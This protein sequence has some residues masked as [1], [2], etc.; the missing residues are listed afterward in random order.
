MALAEASAPGNPITMALPLHQLVR[1]L[2]TPSNMSMRC[3]LIFSVLALLGGC[4][5]TGPRILAPGS[6]LQAVA[7][8][9]VKADFVALGELHQTPGVHTVHHQLL[10][11]MHK[12]RPNMVIAMEMFERD[13]QTVLTQYL[14]GVIDEDEF[15]DRS[16]PWPHY[17]RDYRP[18]IEFAKQ[19]KLKVLAAN[20][21]RPLARQAAQEGMQ[22]V[23]G[24]EHLARST[25]APRDDYW[26]SFQEMMAGHG[27][28]F[29]E[30]GMERFYAA[31]CLKDDTMAEAIVDHLAAAAA[32]SR[33]LAVLICGRAHSDHGWGAVQRVVQR[34]PGIDVRVLTAETVDDLADAVI[35]V[36]AGVADYVVVAEARPRGLDGEGDSAHRAEQNAEGLRPAF[37]FMPDYAGGDEGVLVGEVLAGRP[38]AAAGIE[39]GDRIVCVNGLPTLDL[40]AYTEALDTLKIGSTVKVRVSREGV[41][42]DLDVKVGSRSAR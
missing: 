16:R 41:E 42:V 21:P 24:N 7:D 40:E 19:N 12:R 15:C 30:D 25:T 3:S 23:Q 26:D 10:R 29:G 11:A 32:D 27:G 28:M 1:G 17:A 9:V 36:E 4:A 13:V 2:S 33:P 37:G 20:A 6:D 34:M 8:D 35:G 5:T 38:A 18:V 14:N 22:A 39:P 31:Q